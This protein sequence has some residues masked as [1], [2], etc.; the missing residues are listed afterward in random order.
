MPASNVTVNVTFKKSGYNVTVSDTTNG[1]VEVSDDEPDY[2]DEVTITTNP[3]PGYEPIITVTD[4]NGNP[5]TV[6]DGKFNMPASDVT[7]NVTFAIKG[8]IKF[9]DYRYAEDGYKLMLVGNTSDVNAENENPTYAITYDGE[10]MFWTDDT[11]Y[12]KEI[13]TNYAGTVYAYIVPNATTVESARAKL[14]V[15]S[16][17]DATNVKIERNGDVTGNNKLDSGDWGAV[18]DLLAGIDVPRTMQQRLEA[19][20]DTSDGSG[21]YW[22]GSIKD[23]DKIISKFF[24]SMS[25]GN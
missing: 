24:A 19:D 21:E 14:A 20:V 1:T 12:R 16:A 25:Q 8:T 11:N 17:N 5:V 4:G 23:I 22:Y 7:V 13:E 2:N 6:T 9:I 15:V 3:N 18:S 10:A